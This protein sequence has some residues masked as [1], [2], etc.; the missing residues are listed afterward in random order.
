[1]FGPWKLS[2][3]VCPNAITRFE[4]STPSSA[5]IVR[6]PCGTPSS[7][8][9]DVSAENDRCASTTSSREAVRFS[10]VTDLKKP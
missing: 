9:E 7:E 4:L 8:T 2:G 1:M 10:C 6:G 3:Q 5:T